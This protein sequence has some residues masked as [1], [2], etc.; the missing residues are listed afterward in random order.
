[1]KN[2]MNHLKRCLI[3]TVFVLLF[4]IISIPAKAYIQKQGTIIEN[5]TMR[6]EASKTSKKVAKFVA[7]Q[8]VKVNNEIRTDSGETWYQIYIDDGTIGYVPA[9]KVDIADAEQTTQSESQVQVVKVTE[10][11]GTVTAQTAIRVREKSSTESAQIASMETGDTFLVLEDETAAD[12][13]VWHRI[14]LNDHGTI[15][16]GYVRSD[17]VSVEEIVREDYVQGEVET[18]ANNSIEYESGVEDGSAPYSIVS[19]K[20]VTGKT[21]WYLVDLENGDTNEIEFLL[22]G[23]V[24]ALREKINVG[25][26]KCLILAAVCV[27]IHFY[28]RW[29]A[30]L[31]DLKRKNTK[32]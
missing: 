8:E 31:R 23:G 6:Q 9:S 16:Y 17:L 5:V 22:S 32:L 10:R 11:I 29:R 12:G 3:A 2:N 15:I 21:K 18:P 19:Q 7:G 4:G 13:Y 24:T 20:S 28:V 14:E 1:M 30:A 25:I 26:Y 27:A